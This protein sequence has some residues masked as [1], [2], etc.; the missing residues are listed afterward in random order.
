MRVC[1]RERARARIGHKNTLNLPA[2]K[3]CGRVS[4]KE[5]RSGEEDAVC[6]LCVRSLFEAHTTLPDFKGE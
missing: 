2:P 4:G 6:P 5:R 1:V 3:S